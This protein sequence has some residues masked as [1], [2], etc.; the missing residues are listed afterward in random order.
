MNEYYIVEPCKSS[1]G[2]EIKLK[3]KRFNIEKAASVLEQEGTMM[4]SAAVVVTGAFEGCSISIYESGRVLIKGL[5]KRLSHADAERI[6]KN[7]MKLLEKAGAI[8]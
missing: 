8:S 6:S 3:N 4:G 5:E 1:N 2:F 7:L